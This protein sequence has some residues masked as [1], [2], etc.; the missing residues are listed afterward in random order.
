MKKLLLTLSLLLFV[1]FV[2]A[3]TENGKIG[4]LDLIQVG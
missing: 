2:N 3:Q 4:L 1:F